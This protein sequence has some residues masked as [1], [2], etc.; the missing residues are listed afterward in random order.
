MFGLNRGGLRGGSEARYAIDRPPVVPPL[1]FAC[2]GTVSGLFQQQHA[3]SAAR[4]ASLSA[5]KKSTLAGGLIFLEWCGRGDLNPHD[6]YDH[7]AL[8]LARLP[9]PPHPHGNVPEI[10]GR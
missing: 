7:Q 10:G 4:R 9:V 1:R 8:N 5:H 6:R 2:G 3:G